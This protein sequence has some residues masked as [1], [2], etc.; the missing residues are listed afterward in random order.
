[1]VCPILHLNEPGVDL[2]ICPIIIMK[3]LYLLWCRTFVFLFKATE[4]KERKQKIFY[5]RK[6][7]E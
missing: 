3:G 5:K 7:R 1:L 4:K 2:Y 6:E